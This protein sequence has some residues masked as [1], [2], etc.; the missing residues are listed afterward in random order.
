VNDRVGRAW[1]EWAAAV[2]GLYRES[3]LVRRRIVLH[4]PRSRQPR[5]SSFS[6]RESLQIV[7]ARAFLNCLRVLEPTLAGVGR[8]KENGVPVLILRTSKVGTE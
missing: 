5:A 8:R 7:R 2:M 3:L 4:L 1:W 6:E